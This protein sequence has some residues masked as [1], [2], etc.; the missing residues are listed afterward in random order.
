MEANNKNQ[1]EKKKKIDWDRV[2]KEACR[3]LRIAGTWYRKCTHPVTNE[4]VLEHYRAEDV[5]K[6]YGKDEGPLILDAADKYINYVNL[7]NHL[8]Y[9]E[10]IKS[11]SDDHYYNIY[12]P[13]KHK[14][15]EGG[16]F[17]H[18]DSLLHHIFGEQYEM[19]T[20]YVQLLYMQPMKR[21][22]V[23]VLVSKENGTGKSTFCNFLHALF[24][25]NCVQITN[26]TLRSNFNSTWV[27]KLLVYCE[28]TLL[29]RREDS[30]KIKNLTTAENVPSEAKGK[31]RTMVQTYIKF[32][33]CSNDENRPVILTADDTRHWIRKVPIITN[34][35]PNENFLE[36][37]KKEIPAFLHHLTQRQLSTSGTDRLWFRPEETRTRAWLRVVTGSIPKLDRE[38]AGML[39]DIM[40]E[41]Q[42]K[43]LKYD[44]TRLLLAVK[45][46][47]IPADLRCSVSKT[48]IKNIL[49]SWGLSASKKT[50][51]FDYHWMDGTGVFHE[52]KNKTGK[53]YLI[54]KEILLKWIDE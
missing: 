5:I 9:K 15:Q 31:D 44:A 16:D 53:C 30:E 39:I 37:C 4:V 50:E 10:D 32:I 40:E 11:A 6:D 7:P 45:G 51:R 36:E 41:L 21:L 47:S 20:D 23:L 13:I 12:R 25:E 24:G 48:D 19:G 3:Y 27:S 52:E 2:N 22:P 14:P 38:I 42:V 46:T 54:T 8:N 43:E 29:D 17:S 1:T 34:K 28:E 26:E 35:N 18:I 33:L 49:R